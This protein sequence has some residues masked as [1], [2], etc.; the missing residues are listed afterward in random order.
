MNQ[1][2]VVSSSDLAYSEI[3]IPY[4]KAEIQY[5][6]S[7]SSNKV[8]IMSLEQFINLSI[9]ENEVWNRD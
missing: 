3:K 2:Y 4:Q 1:L 9:L 8:N 7:D 6:M 5:K